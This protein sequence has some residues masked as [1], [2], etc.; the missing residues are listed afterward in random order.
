M[1]ALWAMR[2]ALLKRSWP[3]EA[4]ARV[5]ECLQA[6]RGSADALHAS[7]SGGLWAESAQKLDLLDG[8]AA[9]AT[10]KG[11]N[12]HQALRAV[13]VRSK[14]G[15]VGPYPSVYGLGQSA[16]RPDA[17]R[18]CTPR[19]SR[20]SMS[21]TAQPKRKE[22]L[23]LGI[24]R[25]DVAPS[26]SARCRDTYPTAHQLTGADGRC[27]GTVSGHCHETESA[28]LWAELREKWGLFDGSYLPLRR[29]AR[30]DLGAR[31]LPGP[32][33][34]PTPG[35]RTSSAASLVALLS[36]ARAAARLRK[37]RPRVGTLHRGTAPCGLLRCAVGR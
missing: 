5:P 14:D 2:W 22:L 19:E 23:N 34:E 4:S 32:H 26:G 21:K 1:N 24:P 8:S 36:E 6:R 10:S 27:L 3:R 18:R 17:E 12:A 13:G 11:L 29:R 9:T 35:L 28:R 7:G 31:R 30:A 20:T 15:P 37:R 16:F 25:V 33:A